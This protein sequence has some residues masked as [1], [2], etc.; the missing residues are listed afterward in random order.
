MQVT[1]TGKRLGTAGVDRLGLADR[2]RHQRHLD[3]N[4]ITTILVEDNTIHQ[5][6]SNGINVLARDGAGTLNVTID[7]NFIREPGAFATNSIGSRRAR[8]PPIRRRSGWR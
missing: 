1:I 3:G 2:Q 4:G 5:F 6:S 8:S 7:D